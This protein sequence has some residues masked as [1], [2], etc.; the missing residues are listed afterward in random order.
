MLGFEIRG[1]E[2][3]SLRYD[4]PKTETIPG[5]CLFKVK[6]TGSCGSDMHMW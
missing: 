2:D 5:G 4:V 6:Y 1:K 3:A